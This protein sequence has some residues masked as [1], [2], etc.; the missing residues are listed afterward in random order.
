MK[1]SFHGAAKTVTGSKHL[2]TL[3][4]EL[5]I[6]LDCGLF[7]GMGA[8]SAE[9]NRHFGFDPTKID[10]LILSHAHIDHSGLIPRL[11]KE[12][13]KGRIICTP[14]TFDLCRLMLS[15]SA[16]IQENDV[17]YINKR[18]K[19]QKKPMLDTLY[20]LEDTNKSLDFFETVNYDEW[21]K[22]TDDVTIMFTDSGHVLGSAAINLKLNENDK[23]T[24][25]CFT[26]DIGRKEDPI[27]KKP[28]PFPQADYIICEST[29]GNRL[30]EP[31][32]HSEKHLL[33]IVQRTCVENKGK[34]IIPAFSLDRTQELIYALDQMEHKGLLPPIKVFVD[35]PLSVEATR[36][37]EKHAECYNDDVR[38]YMKKGDQRPFY[39]KNLHY[40]TKVEHSKAINELNEPCIIISSSGMAEAGRI[41][42]HIKNN[43]SDPGNTILMVGYC[44][45]TSLGGR[46][47]NGDKV[48]RVFGVEYEVK[49]KVEVIDSYSAHG[50]YEEMIHYLNCQNKQEV[51]KIFLVHGDED[52][53]VEFR[54]KL[55][56]DNFRKVTIPDSG[57][58]FE[59]N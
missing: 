31:I 32:E 46:L 47:R 13:F 19:K 51:K 37:V 41:K 40:I 7:Q 4:N 18:R 6:L 30:H 21:F 20:T 56:D 54:Q 22:V 26:G 29:Y 48:V 58:S 52:V 9:L 45:P 17:K 57:E 5:N 24:R 59:L 23:V 34:L 15:D 11:V 39:F 38:E 50:D 25:I 53:M 8:E 14:A 12:G 3:T 16:I 27:L 2:L 55:L 43:I 33:E 44:T 10:V 36:V 49:A 35:S 28:Q 1:L 42:H